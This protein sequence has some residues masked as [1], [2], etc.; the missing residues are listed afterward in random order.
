MICLHH[1][2]ASGSDSCLR[3]TSTGVS[4]ACAQRHK[5]SSVKHFTSTHSVLTAW[6]TDVREWRVVR[7]LMRMEVPVGWMYWQFMDGWMNKWI[8]KYNFP[9][10]HNIKYKDLDKERWDV[11][12]MIWWNRFVFHS[13]SVVWEQLNILCAFLSVSMKS[14]VFQKLNKCLS[15]SLLLVWK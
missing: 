8:N 2:D 12:K 15:L 9:C 3:R 6:T 4:A 5:I 10:P 14:L 11:S 13:G 1:E 7:N